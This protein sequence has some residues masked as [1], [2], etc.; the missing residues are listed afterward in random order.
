MT[1]KNQVI[2]EDNQKKLIDMVQKIEK[3]YYLIKNKLMKFLIKQK[4]N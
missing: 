4:M 3:I 1:M 2:I